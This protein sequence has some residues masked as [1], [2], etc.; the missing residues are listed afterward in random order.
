MFESHKNF[1][2]IL[3]HL[4]ITDGY[5][6]I[7]KITDIDA[8]YRGVLLLT[9]VND[10]DKVALNC[11]DEILVLVKEFH[12]LDF[13]LAFYSVYASPCRQSEGEDLWLVL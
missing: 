6:L 3:S 10:L 2:V 7:S 13:S 8:L 4:E 11:D 12:L 5:R 1:F 9:W